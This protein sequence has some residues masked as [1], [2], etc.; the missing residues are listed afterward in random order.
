[1]QSVCRFNFLK[2]ATREFIEAQLAMAIIS[3]EAIFGPARVRLDTSYFVP[4]EGGGC[5]LDIST[6]SGEHIAQVFITL[7]NRQVG[8]DAYQIKRIRKTKAASLS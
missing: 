1:M 3:A 6:K 4:D 7:L 8:E 5:V 2:K